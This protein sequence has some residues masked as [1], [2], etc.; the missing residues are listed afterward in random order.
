MRAPRL[1]DALQLALPPPQWVG[2]FFPDYWFY[3][4]P[5]YPFENYLLVK[6]LA[7]PRMIFLFFGYRVTLIFYWLF[8]L[9]MGTCSI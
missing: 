8:I 6:P 3:P 4:V 7:E 2:M 9:N 5:R 1:N